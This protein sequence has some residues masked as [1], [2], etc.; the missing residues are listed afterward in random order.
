M[1]TKEHALP[2][3]GTAEAWAQTQKQQQQDLLQLVEN[4]PE[5]GVPP[6]QAAGKQPPYRPSFASTCTSLDDQSQQAFLGPSFQ[7]DKYKRQTGPPAGGL[8]NTFAAN[9]A[10][11]LQD[12]CRKNEFVMPTETPN[13]PSSNF[14]D[15]D[16]TRHTSIDMQDANFGTM[17]AAQPGKE[18]PS[19]ED[20]VDTRLS[21]VAFSS[22]PAGFANKAAVWRTKATI[23]FILSN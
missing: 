6:S 3:D 10:M 13:I 5:Y 4:N 14:N 11:G 17:V 23:D 19:I 1:S 22:R 7:Y 15:F 16:F 8:A 21:Q 18:L 2:T 12:M 20:G 9:Q